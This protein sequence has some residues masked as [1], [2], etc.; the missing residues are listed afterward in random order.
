M[1]LKGVRR[2]DSRFLIFFR[3]GLI[4]YKSRVPELL[5]QYLW[6]SAV[7]FVCYVPTL[8]GTFVFDD[9]EAVVKNKNVNPSTP[10]FDIFRNDFWG[11]D[12]TLDISHKSYRPLTVLT[13]RLSTAH[14]FGVIGNANF[15]VFR[16]NYIQANYKFDAFHFHVVNLVLYVILCTLSLPVYRAVLGTKQKVDESP[17]L[18]SIL[19][20]VHPVHTEVVASIVGRA[21]ILS[22]ILLLV[23]FILYKRSI[24][25]FSFLTLFYVSI[26]VFSATLC[27]ET[28]IAVLGICTMYDLF[29]KRWR[30]K[31]FWYR[32]AILAATAAVVLYVRLRIMNFQGPKFQKVDNP[33]A[34]ADSYT[35]RFLTYNYVYFLNALLLFWPQWLCFDWS[36]GC[37]PLLESFSDPRAVFVVIFWMSAAFTGYCVLLKRR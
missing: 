22:S 2:R 33:A 26:L 13:Y 6:I 8:F 15:L 18:C 7:G 21:D 5:R 24:R 31:P 3:L 10:L 4:F 16:L 30:Q 28:A 23:V 36:M 29:Q 17:F 19:F 1:M 20:A 12:I 11:T 25:R 32:Q 35:T 9:Q 14:W 34:F 27:K 37:I